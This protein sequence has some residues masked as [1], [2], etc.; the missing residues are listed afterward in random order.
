M[1]DS[2]KVIA[3]GP[4]TIYCDLHQ[5][6]KNG[7]LLPLEPKWVSV[8]TILATNQNQA[9]KRQL[10]ID[11]VWP[12]SP[13]VEDSLNRA[14]SNLRKW[15]SKAEGVEIR[16]IRGYGYQLME[17]SPTDRPL[18]HAWFRVRG[19]LRP[20]IQVCTII[21]AL[22]LLYWILLPRQKPTLILLNELTNTLPLTMPDT[23]I[24]P[25]R[26]YQAYSWNEGS[27]D[28]VNIY[29]KQRDTQ[30]VSQFTHSTSICQSARWSG[31]G[32]KI[33][34]FEKEEDHWRLKIKPFLGEVERYITAVADIP[35][36][37]PSLVWGA[38]DKTIVFTA[39]IAPGD[40]HGIY[41]ID[42]SEL[43]VRTIH[44]NKDWH[45][46][47]P[48]FSPDFSLLAVLSEASAPGSSNS[49]YNDRITILKASSGQRLLGQKVTG[50]VNRLAWTEESVLAFTTQK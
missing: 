33:A 4:F 31:D 46:A 2:E 15:I 11:Q 38:N 6:T 45:F 14:I 42:L 28:H 40:D 37:R 25:D 35:L 24:S 1:T 49:N 47:W 22:A 34:Y 5:V 8:L 23:A 41:E 18:S 13:G 17:L 36:S 43:H 7:T 48:T 16:T 29:L 19:K 10:I 44:T 50:M 3:V 21:A 32:N 30:G 20:W 9:V 12:N 26:K 27:G 39:R